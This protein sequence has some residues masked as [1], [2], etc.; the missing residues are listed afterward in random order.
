MRQP[1][2]YGKDH[3]KNAKKRETVELKPVIDSVFNIENIKEAT[4]RM[5]KAK[6][7]GKIVLEICK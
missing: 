1:I 2:Y 6:Q 7:F 3:E 4:D 5:E